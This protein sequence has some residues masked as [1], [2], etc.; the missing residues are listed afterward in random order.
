MDAADPRT[1]AKLEAN[2]KQASRRQM[3]KVKY[4]NM[5]SEIKQITQEIADLQQEKDR[6]ENELQTLTELIHR[7]GTSGQ[8]GLLPPPQGDSYE[9]LKNWLTVQ[10]PVAAPTA[11]PTAPTRAQT[12]YDLSNGQ[13]I[14]T[15]EEEL[16]GQALAEDPK[17]K[18]E[19][20]TLRAGSGNGNWV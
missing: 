15:D 18:H 8:C 20:A 4:Q 17:W 7:H 1:E 19:L 9:T 13:E 14:T 3:K 2:A 16:L 12:T 6:L 5:Q 10:L 11:A